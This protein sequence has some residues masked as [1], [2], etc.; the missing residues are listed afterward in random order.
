MEEVKRIRRSALYIPGHKWDL[1]EKGGKYKSDI[2]ILCVED[3]V[4]LHEKDRAREGVCW[5]GL[6][7]R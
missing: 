5:L 7:E 2:V 3:G 6:A 1:L 4:P